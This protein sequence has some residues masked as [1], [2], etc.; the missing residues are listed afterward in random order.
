MAYFD[1]NGREV[2]AADALSNGKLRNGYRQ[3]M[4]PGDYVSFDM[5]FM[6]AKPKGSET[7]I[8]AALRA[9]IATLAKN[10][11]QT[12]EQYLAATPLAEI[13]KMAAQVAMEVLETMSGGGI[14]SR[15]A[16]EKRGRDAVDYLRRNRFN[17]FG[18]MI[19]AEDSDNPAKPSM[20]K[21]FGADLVAALRNA[22]Y[23]R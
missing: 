2:T 23:A 4:K 3:T 14:A 6:D 15:L 18:P 21:A 11:G 7:S 16:D 13:Q 12:P 1:P 17:N 5:N 19:Q 8:D 20:G 9:K 22:R 10:A